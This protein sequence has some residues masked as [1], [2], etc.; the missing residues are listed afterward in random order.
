MVCPWNRRIEAEGDPAFN[1]RPGIPEPD[2][3]AELALSAVGFNRKF[4]GSPIQRP[5]RRGYLR[6]VATALGNFGEA[7]AVTA[8]ER[9]REDE[10]GLVREHVAWA[11]EQ[12]QKRPRSDQEPENA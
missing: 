10:E 8:L 4:K 6:N 7:Q 5:R 12:V 9:A 3:G 1:P 11:L 2:L